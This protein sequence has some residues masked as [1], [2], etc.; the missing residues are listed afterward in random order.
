[1]RTNLDLNDELVAEALALTGAQ[2][3]RE[4]IHLALSANLPA[5]APLGPLASRRPSKQWAEGPALF[6]GV[7][8]EDS[9]LYSHR[10]PPSPGPV[11]AGAFPSPAHLIHC[12][13]AA[14]ALAE[15]AS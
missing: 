4:L 9:E 3:K 1:M 10:P 8:R 2:T 6:L 5:R 11:A 12:G 13:R 15:Q 14:I 7:R